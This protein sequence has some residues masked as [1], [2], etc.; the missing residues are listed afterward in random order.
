MWLS[1]FITPPYW[2]PEVVQEI[3]SRCCLTAS[4]GL[5]LVRLGRQWNIGRW[6]SA[7][8]T[9]TKI[10]VYQKCWISSSGSFGVWT[11]INYLYH[12]PWGFFWRFNLSRSMELFYWYCIVDPFQWSPPPWRQLRVVLP[13]CLCF[14]LQ[15]QTGP[16]SAYWRSK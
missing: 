3:N 2:P 8:V 5:C 15:T 4:D 12:I 6:N 16:L 10:P 9:A 1:L 11:H 13:V 14:L 7:R